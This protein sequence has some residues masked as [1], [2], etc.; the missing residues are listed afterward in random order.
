MN[1]TGRRTQRHRH[2][3]CTHYRRWVYPIAPDG[4]QPTPCRSCFETSTGNTLDRAAVTHMQ[5]QFCFTV[6][7]TR[8]A[9]RNSD[10]TQHGVAHRYY[11]ATCH[12][13]EHRGSRPIFHCDDCGICRVG[14]RAMYRHCHRC[15]MCVP[16]RGEHRCWGQTSQCPVCLEDLH[17]SRENCTYTRCGHALHQGCLRAWC[18]QGRAT[19]PLCVQPLSIVEDATVASNTSL[20]PPT[21]TTTTIVQDA[22]PDPHHEDEPPHDDEGDESSAMA[23]AA[24]IAA[25]LQTQPHNNTPSPPQPSPQ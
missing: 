10:C 15:G 3:H 23:L 24:A 5:C 22:L 11:C 2:E 12:L 13:W 18:A 9:C 19:C 16:K 21:T 4:G 8:S 25:L 17:G 6:Q 20:P 14:S 1:R 7:P